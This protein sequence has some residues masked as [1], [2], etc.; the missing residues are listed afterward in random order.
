MTSAEKSALIKRGLRFAV[1]GL[2]VTALH[3][4]VAVLLINYVLALP[5]VANG[6][7]FSVATLV[8]YV[9]NTSWSF[10]SRLHGRTLGRFMM[11]SGAGLLLAMLVAWAAQM[12]GLHYLLGIGAVALTIPAF[13]FVLHNFWTY[14]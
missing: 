7:A 6:V 5:P 3:A 11:V 13:T 12:A 1:T 10:S 9:I 14:R 2:F 4:V 8:S